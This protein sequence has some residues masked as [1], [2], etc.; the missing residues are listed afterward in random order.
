MRI[1]LAVLLL[2]AGAMGPAAAA[3]DRFQVNASFSLEIE[4]IAVKN[5]IPLV[6]AEGKEYV[7]RSEE[8]GKCKALA[9]GYFL[10]K[11]RYE[12]SILTWYSTT[13]EPAPGECPTGVVTVLSVK[14]LA[15]RYRRAEA[16]R[17]EGNFLQP[18]GDWMKNRRS[19]E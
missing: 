16:E 10:I 7:F 8:G 2:L 12:D 6:G 11:A 1:V 19:K 17:L 15:E 14:Y 5:Q 9:R 18:F 4:N 3:E 13:P